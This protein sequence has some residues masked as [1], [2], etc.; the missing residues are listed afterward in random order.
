MKTYPVL[1][2][3]VPLNAYRL[4]LTFAGD[5]KRVYDFAPHLGHKFYR[6]LSDVKLFNK[7]SVM[8]GELLWATGQDFCPHTL[9]DQSIALD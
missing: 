4:E 7:V 6:I 3:A 8:D 1:K 9:Y 5:E 2:N